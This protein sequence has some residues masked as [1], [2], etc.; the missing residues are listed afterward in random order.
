MTTSPVPASVT[1]AGISPSAPKRG[2]NLVEVS[3]S[4]ACA[5]PSAGAT[6]RSGRAEQSQEALLLGGIIAED[7]AE[8]RGHRDRAVLVD[9]A[10]G[11]AEMLG[12]DHHGDAARLE[13]VVDR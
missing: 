11:H 9:A 8:L 7:A 1:I 6:M 10:N 3:R 2:V 5:S 13:R 4:C 12:L